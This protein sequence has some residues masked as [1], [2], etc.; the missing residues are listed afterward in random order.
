MFVYRGAPKSLFRPGSSTVVLIFEPNRI[1]FAEDL[2][3][4]RLRKGVESRF[5][6]GLGRPLIE[7]DIM[8]RD[9]IAKAICPLPT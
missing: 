4:N 9:P 7:T 8:V 5:S 6:L 2:V 1:E 3:E